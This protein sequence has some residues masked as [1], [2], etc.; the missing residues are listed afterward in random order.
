VPGR[1]N[2]DSVVTLTCCLTR[3]RTSGFPAPG[4]SLIALR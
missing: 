1:G 2:A 4:I 3:L